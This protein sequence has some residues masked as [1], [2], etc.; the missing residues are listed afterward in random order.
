MVHLCEVPLD[1]ALG[2]G[3]QVHAAVQV[4]EGPDAEAVGGV[5]LALQELAARVPDIRQLQQVGGGQQ[6]L[7]VILGHV[8][9]AGVDVV[10]KDV[11]RLGVEPLQHHPRAVQLR[12]SREHHVE[13][14]GTG[15]QHHLAGI[16]V[17]KF[18]ESIAIH[19]W[20]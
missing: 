10:H 4:C 8:H 2:G 20:V 16:I 5:E 1:A 6:R 19:I 18:I 12:E 9:H 3:E 11:E 13:V 17:M 14:G 15:G 7:H